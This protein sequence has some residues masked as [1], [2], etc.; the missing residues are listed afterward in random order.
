[1]QILNTFVYDLKKLAGVWADINL[2]CFDSSL[3]RPVFHLH[4]DLD[5][6]LGKEHNQTGYTRGAAYYESSKVNIALLTHLGRRD[7]YHVLAHE[8][9][10]QKL[11]ETIGM[12][13]SVSI[14]HGA[15]FMAYADRIKRYPGLT[16][17]GATL[18]PAKPIAVG[19][20]LYLP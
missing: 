17:I 16:L 12:S 4:D 20:R 1:M 11:I 5:A 9:V 13:K 8:M 10:H 2:V 14:N 18:Q 15:E 19:N 7:F 6:V 3:K